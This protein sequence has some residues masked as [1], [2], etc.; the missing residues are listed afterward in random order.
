MNT[1]V[2][3]GVPPGVLHKY[4]STHVVCVS[5]WFSLFLFDLQAD[6]N[7]PALTFYGGIHIPAVLMLQTQRE[8]QQCRY[9]Y[10]SLSFMCLR[11]PANCAQVFGISHV[12]DVAGTL[13]V[14]VCVLEI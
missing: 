7:T 4:V 11:V 5:V 12:S 8:Q 14:C 9:D 1:V 3:C 13:C 6:R 10:Q 2:N